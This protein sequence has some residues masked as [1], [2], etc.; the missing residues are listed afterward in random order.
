MVT[1]WYPHSS[2][3]STSCSFI[4]SALDITALLLYTTCCF[5][6]NVCLNVWLSCW[7]VA[8]SST[9]F[10]RKQWWC[11]CTVQSQLRSNHTVC[12]LTDS[13]LCLEKSNSSTASEANQGS[14]WR[15]ETLQ[16]NNIFSTW[17]FRKASVGWWMWMLPK[18][19]T[20]ASWLRPGGRLQY[21]PQSKTLRV[22]CIFS[23]GFLLF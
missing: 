4:L 10:W 20:I 3:C 14:W 23:N 11:W 19:G 1:T 13:N 6:N 22:R 12:H 5:E 15:F 2:D 8:S 18:S 16:T 7:G 9:A 17:V 21:R